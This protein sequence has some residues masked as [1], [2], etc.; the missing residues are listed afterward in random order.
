MTVFLVW[1]T[2]ACGQFVRAL[3]WARDEAQAREVVGWHYG[4]GEVNKVEVV[5]N[6]RCPPPRDCRI[7][8][9]QTTMPPG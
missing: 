2:R 1:Y 4:G 3:V 5:K 8:A 7:A 6:P 9:P